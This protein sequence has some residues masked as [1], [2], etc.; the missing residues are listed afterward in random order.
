MSTGEPQGKA[1]KILGTSFSLW[2]VENLLQLF[3]Q[4][5]TKYWRWGE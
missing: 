2:S 4:W 5:L 3:T 1:N